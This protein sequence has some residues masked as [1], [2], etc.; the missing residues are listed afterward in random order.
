VNNTFVRKIDAER[1][2]LAVV[3]S[4]TP[5]KRQLTGLSAAAIDSWRRLALLPQVD[6]LARRLLKVGTLC[7]L[8]SDRS[9]ESFD[10]LD[11]GLMEKIDAEVATLRNEVGI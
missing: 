5:G 8:L 3:N 1:K 10:S 7:Q 2:I 6:E 4:L 9:H 11:P